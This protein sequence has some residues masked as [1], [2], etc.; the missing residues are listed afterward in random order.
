MAYV[1]YSCRKFGYLIVKVFCYYKPYNDKVCSW[2]KCFCN[3]CQK[4]IILPL[5]L[6]RRKRK[7]ISCGCK[8]IENYRKAH[9]KH[10]YFSRYNHREIPTQRNNITYGSYINMLKRCY[11]PNAK[12][13]KNYGGRGIS[14]CSRW[15]KSFE[16]FI[17]DVGKRPGPEYSID[18]IDNDGNYKPGNVKWSTRSE[19]NKNRRK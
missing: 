9:L 1:E 13:Y 7:T 14:V 2:W 4:E 18:R 15:R 17:K 12:G 6:F 5:V 8:N 16:N 19:Q 10:G 11:E 3:G